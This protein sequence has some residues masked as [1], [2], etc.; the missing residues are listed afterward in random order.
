MNCKRCGKPKG[1]VHTCPADSYV[2][3]WML[4]LIAAVVLGAGIM[5]S[6]T[7]EANANHVIGIKGLM[8]NT[9]E[10]VKLYLKIAQDKTLDGTTVT[11]MVNEKFGEEVCVE[12]QERLPVMSVKPVGDDY[13][14]G[15]VRVT[16]VEVLILRP[17]SGTLYRYMYNYVILGQAIL[18]DLPD[19][20]IRGDSVISNFFME[21]IIGII[22]SALLALFVYYIA[23]PEHYD[24]GHA[25]IVFIVLALI[26]II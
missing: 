18:S 8:C 22:I 2:Q 9:P 25:L 19:N 17:D 15:I 20:L 1:L 5:F 12:E 10:Q 3:N 4:W 24:W 14:L 26:W 6:F 21:T 11:T 16:I 13:D 7:R 23:D